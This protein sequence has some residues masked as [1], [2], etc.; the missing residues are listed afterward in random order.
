MLLFSN[1]I[2]RYL[3]GV[4]IEGGSDTTAALLQTI[5][6][7]LVAFPDVQRKAHEEIDHVFGEGQIPS[8][9][10]FPNLPYT[11]AIIKEVSFS[12]PKSPFFE[13]DSTFYRLIVLD[14]WHL[15]RCLIAP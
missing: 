4:L 14:H 2:L 7:A 1:H 8:L 5:V 10:D 13:H 15:S 9:E 12:P 3:G 6:L 11:D